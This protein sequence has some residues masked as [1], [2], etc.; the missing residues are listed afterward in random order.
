LSDAITSAAAIIGISVALIGG[1]VRGGSG[2]ESANDWPA[3]VASV[4]IAFNGVSMI[5]A[6][7]G[8]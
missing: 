4:V 1:R 3:L 2:W 8:G 6:H 7:F 5:R